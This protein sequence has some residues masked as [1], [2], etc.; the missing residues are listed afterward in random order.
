MIGFKYVRLYA[1]EFAPQLYPRA[2]AMSNTSA[3]N[4]AA[5]DAS[6]HPAFAGAPFFECVLGPGDALYIPPR[7]WHYVVALSPSWSV[8]FWSGTTY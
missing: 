7:W 2:G 5:P 8:S 3:V 6:A 1:P 4:V